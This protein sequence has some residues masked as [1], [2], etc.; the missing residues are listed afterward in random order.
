VAG[1]IQPTPSISR[2]APKLL[3]ITYLLE[4]TVLFGGVKV[5]LLQAN[6]LHRRGHRVTVLSKGSPPDW[7]QLEARFRQ[8]P[9]F[10][11]ETVPP[12]DVTVATYWT[13]LEAV[14]EGAGEVA[15]Y[16]QG[17]EA[18]YTHNDAEH[19]AILDAYRQPV[20]GLVVAPHLGVLLRRRFHRP[21]RVVLQPLEPF[22]RP[23]WRGPWPAPPRRPRILVTA[24][25]EIDWKGTATALEALAQLRRDGF[26]CRVVRLS[27]W[28]QTEAERAILAADE[29]HTHLGPE[30]AAALVRSCDLLL[31]PSWEQEGFGLPVLE[32]MASGVPVVASDISCFR[33]FTGE[34][35]IRVPFDDPRAFAA[36][37]AELLSQAGEWRRRRRAGIKIARNY[38]EDRAAQSAE[39]ALRWVAS[40]A[41]RQEAESL[42]PSR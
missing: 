7:L 34:A 1:E 18:S 19:P 21:S 31:A 30:E 5:I 29:F 8:V 41:W 38:R 11:P 40:G 39:E 12:A 3:T 22:W 42:N 16:C 25:L 23:R 6:L 17:F 24:P 36:A 37:A 27:Q 26:P 10:S 2:A 35:A 9:V 14:R 4:D 20:P 28:P 33:D 15:H 13:T 32:A